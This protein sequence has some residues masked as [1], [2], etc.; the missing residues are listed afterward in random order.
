[1]FFVGFKAECTSAVARRLPK[2]QRQPS[3][4]PL[5]FVEILECHHIIL[6]Q[7]LMVNIMQSKYN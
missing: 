7:R 6:T 2:P 3:V 4:E 1:M 5:E